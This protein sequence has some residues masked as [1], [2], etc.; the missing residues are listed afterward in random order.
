MVLIAEIILTVVA[1]RRGWRWRALLPTGVCSL[2]GILAGLGTGGSPEALES[3]LLPLLMIEGLAI[4]VLIVMAAH[5]PRETVRIDGAGCAE[6]RPAA[7][8]GAA[9]VRHPGP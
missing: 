8:P 9:A 6:P 7:A 3:A 5:A 4:I 1:W 2:I